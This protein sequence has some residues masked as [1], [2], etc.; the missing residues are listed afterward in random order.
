MNG[1]SP[2][3]ALR[4]ARREFRGGLK[5]FRVFL[6]SLA[7]G[8]AA[9]A[10]VGSLSTSIVEG[11]RGDAR[12]LLG[13]DVDLRLQHRT[14][15]ADQLR[16]LDLNAARLSA[17]V[18]M[19]AMGRAP[20][21]DSRSLIELKAVD[22]AYPLTGAIETAPAA[23]L[24]DLLGRGDGGD[25]GVIV[26]PN[27][28]TKLGIGI[29]DTLSIGD[30]V[31]TVRATIVKE[32]DRVTSIAQFGP[33]AMISTG[34]LNATGL[35]QPGSQVRY[36]YRVTLPP[37]TGL[38]QW[39][40]D[41][42]EAFPQAGWRI[43][44]LDEAAPGMRRFIDRMTLFLTF[45]GLTTLL[46]GG[47]GV[48]NAVKSYL[49]GKTETIATLKCLGASGRLIFTTYFLQI[50]GLAVIGVALGLIV[51][52]AAP[53]LAAEALS[54]LLPVPPRTGLYLAPLA[55]AAAFGL[56]TAATFALL[57]LA[58]AQEIPAG[59]L[60]RAFVAPLT[61]RPKAVYL[62]ALLLGTAAL[63]GLTVGTASRTDAALWFVGGAAATFALLRGAALAVMSLAARLPRPRGAEWRLAVT[64][65]H[66][67]GASTPSTVVS[68]GLGLAVLIA[69]VLI[70]ANLNRQINERLPN[71]APSLFF[72]DIQPNQV[73]AF[74]QTVTGFPDTSDFRRVPSLRG[75]IVKIAGVPVEEVDIAP[76]ARWAVRGDRAL[77]YAATASEESDIVAGKWWPENYAGPPLISLDADLARGFGVD[78][79]DTLTFNILGR[80]ITAEIASLREIDWRS[81]RFDFAV[82][83]APGALEGAPHTH[84]AAVHAPASEE[85]AIEKAV[86]DGFS[87]VSAIRV[88]EALEAVSQILAGIGTA[89]RSTASVTLLAGALVLSGA[90][91]AARRRRI[92]D[93]V[94]F[95]VLGATRGR[96]LKAFLLEYG[97]LGL[98]TG[99]IATVIGAITAWAVMV[100]L[101]ESDW[102]FFPGGVA[103]TV[104]ACLAVTLAIGFAGTWR[105]LG[106]KAA[107]H[108]R[109]E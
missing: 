30:A 105:A 25:W 81:L 86:S 108:L 75:R 26:D 103:M 21:A 42:K 69:I 97:L 22:S 14:A 37:Q 73:A 89:V 49:D 23:P 106:Q 27:L 24:A 56:L 4:L 35:I 68:L 38:H 29:G 9:I 104:L 58:R 28:L 5:G 63:A 8:V 94:V 34:A 71:A 92:Y 78:V 39:I 51:G 18:R 60:F 36:H 11:L 109:N 99:L 20:E 6:A 67:P 70:Q 90:V 45:V 96:V 98:C 3:L 40:E 32:P 61:G 66:R 93:A 46:V 31:F 102:T 95:K 83:F 33:R 53:Y 107:P 1:L 101:M 55:L 77:T 7:L 54:G 62:I 15:E 84:I 43:R 88:R 87:N 10:G 100:F 48:G 85:A 17:I 13:G 82:I 16:Y 74:D 41:L 76:D 57:P 50:M 91:A 44:G 64:N 2:G 47:I 12:F 65:L 52:A 19:R 59:N 72:L 80:E 79:G